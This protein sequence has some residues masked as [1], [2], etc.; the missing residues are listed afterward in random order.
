MVVSVVWD[1]TC[2][3]TFAGA[4]LN[5]SAMEAGTAENEDRKCCKYAALA[6]AYQF[7]PIALETIG[8]YFES[9]GVILRAISRRL[10]EAKGEPREANCFRQKLAIAIQRG[11]LR[12]IFS[13]PVVRGYR[14]SGES[15]STQPFI[16]F[17]REF[18][19]P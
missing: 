2:V 8:V 15:S 13:Q 16:L 12:S 17:L 19:F 7:E 10:V 14:G 9:T 11:N 18:P 4:H 1:C 3:D 6:E 5:W